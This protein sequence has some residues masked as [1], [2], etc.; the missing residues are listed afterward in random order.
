MQ[1]TRTPPLLDAMYE[2]INRVAAGYMELVGCSNLPHDHH[3]DP[4]TQFIA[5]QNILHEQLELSQ[6][7]EQKLH[8]QLLVAEQEHESLKELIPAF[9]EANKKQRVWEIIATNARACHAK[10]EST[11]T[12][13][14]EDL[15]VALDWVRE[16]R[17]Q[18]DCQTLLLSSKDRAIQSITEESQVSN[19]RL[20]N[21]EDKIA[22]LTTKLQYA[23]DLRHRKIQKLLSE[24]ARDRERYESELSALRDELEKPYEKLRTL[25]DRKDAYTDSMLQEWSMALKSPELF[26]PEHLS[27]YLYA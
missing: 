12:S 26:T 17:E 23:R 15:E 1:D 13:L 5:S 3:E 19:V 14:R 11:M 2:Q 6:A 27:K 20:K 18:L 22:R 9:K 21:A 25:L 8:A 24:Q 10:T 4:Y 16:V 7:R